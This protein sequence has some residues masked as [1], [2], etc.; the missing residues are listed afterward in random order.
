MKR[1]DD[2]S[3]IKPE[4]LAIHAGLDSEPVAGA[5]SV[6]IYQTSTF[7]FDSAAEGAARFSG[8]DAG[9]AYTRLGNP[10][11]RA[12]ENAVCALEGGHDAVATATGMAAVSTVLLALLRS[13]DHVVATDAVYGATR[14]LL[15]RHLSK[16]GIRTT[17]VASESLTAVR[18]AVQP[19][20]RLLYVETP[21]NPTLAL[22]DLEGCAEIARRASLLLVADNTF[23]SPLLQQPLRLGADVV[24]HSLTKYLNGHSDVVAGMIV[25]AGPEIH[26]RLV[27]VAHDLGTT[28][29]P[30]QAWLVLRGL[31][32]VALR[33]ERAQEN[34]T[35]LAEWL[36]RQPGV[37]WVSYPGLE[38]HPQH[39]LM[40]RQ[41]KGPGSMIAFGVRGGLEAARALID[42]LTL[43]VRA[44]SLGGVE[45]LVEH[46]A[47][48]THSKMSSAER[49]SAGIRDDLV[50]LSVGCEAFEDLRADLEH[51]LQSV[52]VPALV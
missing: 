27:P 19:N 35:R 48:M 30:H 14:S 49:A 39:E 40:L 16:F 34:A 20:T 13:G 1:S 17:W 42:A 7:S 18:D 31:R 21:A 23:A 47:S 52:E 28:M 32:T 15:A 12:L 10:T 8:S 11:V 41:M 4:T 38:T 9:Y 44:V 46:P 25:S 2:K 37:A 51:A 43:A 6:P 45:T 5:V 3:K 50:R 29:D 26:E 33:V 36:A 24:V 22:T